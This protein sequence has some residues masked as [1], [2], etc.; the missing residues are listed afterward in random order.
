MNTRFLETL[1]WLARL[2]SFS[3]T[4]EALN[5]TQPA[6]SN[7]IN[8]L[9]E[10]LNV[11]LYDRSTREFN[12]TSAGRRI[13][14]HAEE[15][16]TLSAELQELATS[17]MPADS[18]I[19]IGVVELVTISWLPAFTATL[20]E[21]F[22]K[23]SFYIGTGTTSD[24]LENLA[25]GELDIAFIVGPVNEPRITSYPLFSAKLEWLAN[26]E[27]FDTKTEIDIIE[28]SRLP[29]LLPRPRTSGYD[30]IIEYFRTYGIQDV[31]SRDRSL[32]LD[33]NYSFGTAAHMVRSGLGIAA[34]PPFFFGEDIKAGKVGIVPVRQKLQPNHIT[35]CVKRPAINPVLDRL[36][37]ISAASARDYVAARGKDDVWI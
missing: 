25:D 36:I 32:I 24:L 27:N 23:S 31:P 17:E 2:R 37:E 18:Q 28:L 9:E 10:L 7:R 1:V 26:T 13:L 35:A 29:L 16:V 12:L 22:P 6:I 11:Q 8:K 21:L 15:I 3:R 19:R 5:A 30:M 34:L 4:A 14:R 33:C 20:A